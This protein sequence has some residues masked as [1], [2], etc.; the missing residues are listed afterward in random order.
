MPNAG[1]QGVPLLCFDLVAAGQA[2]TGAKSQAAILSSHRLT[3][4]LMPPV[5]S[6]SL[7]ASQHLHGKQSLPPGEVSWVAPLFP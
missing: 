6:H 1:I 7:P 5:T 2:V 4:L 3:A